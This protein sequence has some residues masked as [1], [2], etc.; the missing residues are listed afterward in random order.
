MT[1]TTLHRSDRYTL[2]S[3]GNGIAYGLTKMHCGAPIEHVFFQGSDARQFAEERDAYAAT[4]PDKSDADILDII[5]SDTEEV[6]AP[7]IQR[8]DGNIREWWYD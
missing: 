5:W 3:F 6:P 8:R 1:R 7:V 4:F 2:V